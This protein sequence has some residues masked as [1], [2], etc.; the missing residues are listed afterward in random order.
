MNNILIARG[1]S[2]LLAM[3]LVTGCASPNNTQNPVDKNSSAATVDSALPENSKAEDAASQ[4]AALEQEIE[5]TKVEVDAALKGRVLALDEQIYFEAQDKTMRCAGGS[6]GSTKELAFLKEIYP[7]LNVADKIL[8]FEFANATIQ[9]SDNLAVRSVEA[10]PSGQKLG[11][12]YKTKLQKKFITM[13][14]VTYKNDTDSFDVEFFT[15]DSPLALAKEQYDAAK[16]SV[17]EYSTYL[18]DSKKHV[19]SWTKDKFT[20]QVKAESEEISN[21]L[22]EAKIADIFTV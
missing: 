10:V 8:K 4:L 21:Q 19:L 16:K 14:T 1:L 22:I 5:K 7:D 13:G 3:A 18:D 9:M 2:I 11:E 12:I 6:G 17:G 15:N 20:Y